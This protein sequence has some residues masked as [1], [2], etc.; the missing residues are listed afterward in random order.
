MSDQ[1]KTVGQWLGDPIV[2]DPPDFDVDA[3]WTWHRNE[4]VRLG[5]LA[6]VDGEPNWAAAFVADPGV[7]SCPKCRADYWAFGKVQQCR[8]CG[9]VFPT[10]AWP[11]YSDGVNAARLYSR[12]GMVHNPA[13][14]E[15]RL[16]N[17]YYRH[18]FEHPPGNTYETFRRLDWPAIVAGY[19]ATP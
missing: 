15:S 13:R 6:T 5:G 10:G 11:M 4:V 8:A 14:H 3:A 9:F 2:V 17:P 7:C 1:L 18:G 16:K 12:H 19:E